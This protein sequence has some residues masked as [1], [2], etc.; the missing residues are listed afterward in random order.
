MKPDLKDDFG[1]TIVDESQ[2]KVNEVPIKQAEASAKHHQGK[3]E[4]L[5]N[6]VMPLLKN[7][8]VDDGKEYIHWPER[9]KKMQEFIAKVNKIV[10]KA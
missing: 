3:V 6:A 1:F 4:E 5:Y 2:I 9:S 7:L 8:A 10:G